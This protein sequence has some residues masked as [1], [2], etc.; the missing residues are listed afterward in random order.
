MAKPRK[1]LLWLLVPLF[2][3]LA[4]GSAWATVHFLPRS[5]S[6]TT[7]TS[8][9]C[10]QL[11]QFVMREELNGKSLWTQYHSN[12]LQYKAGISDKARNVQ[13]VTLMADQVVKVLS[14][15]LIIYQEM[16]K[17]RSCLKSDFN[18]QLEAT[19]SDTQMTIDFLLGTTQIEGQSFD[20]T[21]GAWNT[22]FY[23][24]YESATNY[25]KQ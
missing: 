24:I 14:S 3:V 22:D 7:S 23:D 19:I 17:Y 8:P 9:E 4:V 6:Q 21:T 1:A 12:V 16:F 5:S 18:A 25:I 10:L 20:P 15:D 2:S 11:Q 13:L